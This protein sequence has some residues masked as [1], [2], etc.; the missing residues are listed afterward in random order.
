[1]GLALVIAAPGFLAA[2]IAAET[3]VVLYRVSESAG[4]TSIG[5]LVSFV[6]LI[7]LWYA[8]ARLRFR[9]RR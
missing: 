9:I 5:A 6:A 1:M 3:S 8:P 4:W 2:G 7:V